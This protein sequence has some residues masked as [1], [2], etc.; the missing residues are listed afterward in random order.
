MGTFFAYTIKA[1]L[2]LIAYYFFYKLL[3]SKETFHR[4]NRVALVS[5][6]Q[7]SLVLPFVHYS[8]SGQSSGLMDVEGLVAVGYSASG[9]TDTEAQTPLSMQIIAW[10]M[11]LYLVGVVAMAIRSLIIYISLARVLHQ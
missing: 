3:F 11:I 4:F 1:A 2:C 7:L 8:I 6:M 10:A 5:L 9:L